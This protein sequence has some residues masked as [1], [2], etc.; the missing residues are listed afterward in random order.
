MFWQSRLG[1]LLKHFFDSRLDTEFCGEHL[2]HRMI[3]FAS[4]AHLSSCDI[5]SLLNSEENC[6]SCER[7]SDSYRSCKGT[8]NLPR[9]FIDVICIKWK[10][11]LI[12]AVLGVRTLRS[13]R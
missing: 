1:V 2:T 9:S 12:N 11:L 3:F 13:W 5:R 7:I 6:E 4:F 8:F 10:V